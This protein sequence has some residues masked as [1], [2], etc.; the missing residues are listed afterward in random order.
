MYFIK[1]I[2][3]ASDTYIVFEECY[4]ITLIFETL[5]YFIFC[6]RWGSWIKNIP[7]SYSIKIS[8][9]P[10]IRSSV[11]CGHTKKKDSDKC[12]STYSIKCIVCMDT[13]IRTCTYSRTHT[14][15]RKPFRQKLPIEFVNIHNTTT[16]WIYKWI[17]L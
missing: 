14:I 9:I 3:K 16:L 2:Y 10:W 12:F 17:G 5:K 6:N 11:K 7:S 4:F 15:V 13:N 1:C 8:H